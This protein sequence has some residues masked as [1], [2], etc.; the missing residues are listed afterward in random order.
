MFGFNIKEIHSLLIHINFSNM[1]LNRKTQKFAFLAT[2]V[3]GVCHPAFSSSDV[4]ATSIEVIQQNQE[5][6]GRLLDK[7]TGEPIIGA[8]VSVKGTTNGAIT[9][10]DGY[11]TLNASV[12]STLVISFIGYQTLEVKASADLQVIEMS[13]DAETLDEVVVVGYGTQ[14][15]SSITGSVTSIKS[16]K[17]KSVTTPSVA[18]MLQGKVAGVQVSPVSGQPGAGVSIRVRGIGSISG[19]K[20]PLWVIDGVVGG[21]MADLNPNDIETISILKDGSATALY[22]SRGANGVVQ[23]TTKRASAGMSQFDASAKFGVSQLQ[24]G[25]L[26]MMNGAEYY[27][28]VETAYRNAGQ[29]EQ[30][31]WLQP[32]LRERNFD[33]WDFATQNALTQNYNIAY[34][35]GNDKIKSYIS[36]DYYSEEGAIKG[37][38]YDRF[39]MRANTDYVVNKRLTLKSKVSLSYKET[40]NQEHSLSYTS[41]TP[42]DTPYDSQGNIK[43]GKESKPSDTEAATAN[44]DDYWYSDGGSNYFYDNQLNWSKSRTNAMDIGFGF[45]YKIFDWLTF[46]SNNKVGFSNSYSDSYTD[47]DSQSGASKH[48]TVYTGNSNSRAIYTSQMLRML[49]TFNDVHEVNAFLGYDYDESRYWSSSAQASNIYPGAE[50]VNAGAANQKASGTKSEEKNAA[51]FF[52][53]NY[54]YDGKYLFQFSFRRDGS[55]RF[56]SNKRWATFWSIGGGW[57]MHEEEFIKNLGFINELKPRVSYGIT[58]NLPAGA[59]EWVTKFDITQQ[60]ANQIAFYSNYAGNPNLSWEQTG[61]F[62]FGLD[63]RLFDRVNI[64]F[65][66]YF[67][68]VKNLIYL[69]HLSAVTG[70]NRQT[71]NDGKLENKGFE[72]TITPELIKTK[73]LYWDVT[74]N[75]GYNRNKVTSLPDGDDLVM[76]ATAVG[77]PYMNWYMPEWAGVD[78]MTGTPLWFVV[79]EETGEKT[80][81]GNYDKATHVLLDSSASPLVNG[82]FGTNLTW[83]G[84]SLNANFTFSA[85]AMI[86]NGMRAGSLDR[87]GERPSQPA[88]ALADGWSRWEKPGDI[89]T[90]PQLIA[91]GNN[92]STST[93]TR[94]LEPGDYLKLKSIS[95]SY[96]LPKKWLKSLNVNSLR[97]SVGGENLLTFTKFSG[98]DPE[99]LLSS[100]FNGTTSSSSGQLYPSV[101]RFTVGLNLNF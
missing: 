32:Y 46:E 19:N 68:K 8:N 73:D 21:A 40:F 12:G 16:D 50:I 60:Y 52:N 85:G 66:G 59:Y 58:G 15:K 82:G 14:R 71:A 86:Y 26:R 93:S 101:R 23:V 89:A 96:D 1:K 75:L 79:D 63:I 49:K 55:S 10:I 70:Y 39:T 25:N 44:P 2:A 99:I 80:V 62:D 57:N 54:S 42:W 7:K 91:G 76:Q 24:K 6:R 81:T 78:T 74:F 48:G 64:T 28:Y 30:Q 22:G 35:Y 56:G 51:I 31:H 94:Y 38:D 98:D 33:W 61:S 29:L 20:E 72:I 67:K 41:Y 11:Y 37:F 47:P 92:K 100:R 5:I 45:D 13:E 84:F 27:D 4:A 83:K 87:D 43:T 3:L 65:D 53:G 9:D 18:D 90:H 69:K 97:I 77:Y 34:R 36:G 88:M 17:L 95:L